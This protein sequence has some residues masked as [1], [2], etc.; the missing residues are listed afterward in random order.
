M[1]GLG[2]KLLQNCSSAKSLFIAAPYIKRDALAKVLKATKAI[3][4]IVCVTRWRP[5]DIVVGAS[6]VGCRILVTERGG[7]FRLHPSLHAKYYRF[8]D[9]S[10][11]GSANL[12]ASAM[13]WVPQ[14]NLEILCGSGD[15]FDQQEFERELLRNSREVSEAEFSSWEA[16]RQI[17]AQEGSQIGQPQP[18]LDSWRPSTRDPRNLMLVYRE[19]KDE[20][21]STDEERA[22]GRD[23]RALSLPSGLTDNRIKAWISACILA[24]PFANTVKQLENTD[25]LDAANLLAE[26]YG[27]GVTEARRDMETVHNWLSFLK[28]RN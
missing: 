1:A 27:L 17:T 14:P 18:A 28:L 3:D 9:V 22:A 23:I 11:I 5:N 10:L 8:D 6:D 19:R 15:D 2:A 20:I 7:S 21:A 12:T 26:T 16:L 13:G 24:T 4:S 25:T